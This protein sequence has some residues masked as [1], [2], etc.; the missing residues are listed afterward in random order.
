MSINMDRNARWALH[1][2]DRI[3]A[4]RESWRR[5]RRRSFSI[6]DPTKDPPIGR[7]NGRRVVAIQLV[8]QDCAPRNLAIPAGLGQQFHREDGACSI[9]DLRDADPRYRWSIYGC[10]IERGRA[11]GTRVVD[12]GGLDPI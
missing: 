1:R 6:R 2:I 12:L 3:N 10:D 11:A 5:V 4:D 8:D 7:D 9:R